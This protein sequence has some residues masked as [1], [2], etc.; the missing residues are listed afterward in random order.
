M[1]ARSSIALHTSQCGNQKRHMRR[2]V[3]SV[4]TTTETLTGI[5]TKTVWAEFTPLAI[6][7]GA[8]NLGQGF[9][10][11]QPEEFIVKNTRDA[12]D[13]GSFL[14]YARS[15]GHPALVNIIADIYSEK[16]GK[17]L[18]PLT[19]ILVTAGGT[20]AIYLVASSL[21][22]D[23]AKGLLHVLK[24]D[25]NVT[26]CFYLQKP[27]QICEIVSSEEFVVSSSVMKS[28]NMNLVY[29][30]ATFH[31]STVQIE[32]SIISFN[33]GARISESR[34]S[35]E[36]SDVLFSNISLSSSLLE[37]TLPSNITI[38]NNMEVTSSSLRVSLRSDQLENRSVPLI[39]VSKRRTRG[40]FVEVEVSVDGEVS[41]RYSVEH[42]DEEIIIKESLV[43]ES[44]Q[45]NTN[46]FHRNQ[47]KFRVPSVGRR[48]NNNR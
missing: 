48:Y 26:D 22:S 15:Q 6:S 2:S 31:N 14:Q 37:I 1:L 28:L 42:L 36:K 43:T 29:N 35:F 10:D 19:N 18:D 8:I 3:R 23:S 34:I 16:I 41:E 4:Q 20:E 13:E 30:D 9:P 5:P 44:T 40:S 21:F 32:E 33:K 25:G 7:T 45:K 24:I 39:R 27:S 38:L 46:P 47:F 17:P 11:F 12:L